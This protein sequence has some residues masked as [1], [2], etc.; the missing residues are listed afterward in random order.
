L[1]FRDLVRDTLQTLMAHK[2]RAGLTMFGL[3]WG[4]VSIVLMTAAGDG[5]RE[6][7]RQVAANF[8]ENIFIVFPGRTSMQAG[9]ERAGRRVMW[10]VRDHELLRPH[11]PSCEHI[12]PELTRSAVAVRSDYNAGSLLVS[13]SQPPY[14]RLRALT[15]AEGRFFS[16]EDEAQGRRVAFLGA[17]AKKQLFGA[18]NAIGQSISI[19]GFPYLVIG[20]MEF[21][22]QDS[23]YD[24]R[25]VNKVFVP[26]SAMIRDLP[27]PPPWPPNTVDQ[28][29]VKAHTLEE[30]EACVAQVRRGLAALHRFDPED[31]MAAAIWDTVRESRAF[32]TMT[33][34]MK[35]FLGAIGV[36]TLLLG[37]IGTMNV[38]LVA[39]RER[40]REIGLRMSVGATRRQIQM[41]FFL[42]TA[43][44][45][46]SSG[47]L[48]LGFALAVCHLVNKLPMPQYFAGLM[49]SW[50]TGAACVALLGLVAFL[51]ALYPASRAASIDPVQA[52][53]FE[54]GG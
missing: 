33:D 18:R 41:M 16:W 37:G 52:L 54:A 19:A 26:F 25:D 28:L 20:V 44:I 46:F 3:M 31:T 14:Q 11:A 10:T 9:G 23:S 5:F 43:L 39:V 6:G 49:P 8:G 34:G 12:L 51:S 47:A 50:E 48:G 38:M 7:Q 13:G 1:S 15:V 2:L 35:Y 29:I 53:H 42:E 21:K 24:G 30:H 17:D 40:T 45:V 32:K 22:D 27:Q 4:I 36:V